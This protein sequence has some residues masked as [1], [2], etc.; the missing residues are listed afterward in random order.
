MD[1]GPQ[2][3]DAQVFAEYLALAGARVLDVGCGAGRMTRLLSKMGG[4]VTGLD[5]DQ[6]QLDR[7]RRVEPTDEETYGAGVAQEMPFADASFDI[8][9]FFNSV[10]HIPQP[11]MATGLAEA[12]RVLRAGGTL[13]IAEPVAAGPFFE[14]QKPFHDET[15]VRALALQAIDRR[16]EGSANTRRIAYLGGTL[17]E[18]FVSYRAG[19]IAIDAKRGQL[20]K[21]QV[22]ELKERFLRFGERRDDGIHFDQPMQATIM[23]KV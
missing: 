14:M 20:G 16:A 2:K 17:F 11:A 7:A 21:E 12:H 9:V 4:Q 15:E 13:F 23:E 22:A 5:P 1:F 19:S 8:V 10:H 3:S 18:S 6:A